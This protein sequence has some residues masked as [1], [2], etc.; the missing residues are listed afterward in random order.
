V[1]F[2]VNRK[3]ISA[4]DRKWKVGMGFPLRHYDSAYEAE[5]ARGSVRNFRSQICFNSCC[6]CT[7]IGAQLNPTTWDAKG[8]CTLQF[9]VWRGRAA[10][11]AEYSLME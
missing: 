3:V 1:L 11:F 10:T 5:Q 7:T 2:A 4:N 9:Q 8:T 6:N